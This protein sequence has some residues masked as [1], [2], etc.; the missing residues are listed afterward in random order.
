MSCTTRGSYKSDNLSDVTPC[1]M[2]QSIFFSH[3]YL[4]QN[5][6]KATQWIIR[7]IYI[8]I[9][10]NQKFQMEFGSITNSQSCIQNLT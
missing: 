9:T 6:Y 10:Q 7:Y 1:K 8:Y 5:D 2:Y 3:L 4:L